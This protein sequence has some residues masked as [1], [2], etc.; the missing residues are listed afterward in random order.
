M[1]PIQ[2][3]ALNY[4]HTSLL[5]EGRHNKDMMGLEWIRVSVATRSDTKHKFILHRQ[6]L[7]DVCVCKKMNDTVDKGI[8]THWRSPKHCLEEETERRSWHAG[9]RN[10]FGQNVNMRTSCISWLASW[11]TCDVQLDS[12]LQHRLLSIWV[13][14]DRYLNSSFPLKQLYCIGLPSFS[15][16]SYHRP[17]CSFPTSDYRL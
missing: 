1:I 10:R 7:W 6:L 5:E 2:T 16:Q 11:H 3:K 4:Q 8:L 13:L 15:L 14:F 17:N 9:H 12:I